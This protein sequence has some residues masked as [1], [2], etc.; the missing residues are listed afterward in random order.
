MANLMR[1]KTCTIC[2]R[3]AT[4]Y[5]VTRQGHTYL[6]NNP[7]CDFELLMRRGVIRKDTTEMGGKIK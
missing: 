6:C 4:I 3:Q 5:R 7:Q 2:R 1:H